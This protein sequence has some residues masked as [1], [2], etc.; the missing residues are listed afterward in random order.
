MP[1]AKKRDRAVDATRKPQRAH[2]RPAG[3]PRP[4]PSVPVTIVRTSA[5]AVT[6]EHSLPAVPVIVLGHDELVA[7]DEG[8]AAL[9]ACREIFV[10][11]GKLAWLAP[12]SSDVAS[13]R[14]RFP[15]S[16][17]EPLPNTRLRELLSHHARWVLPSRDDPSQFE[18][19]PVPV[20]AVNAIAARRQW[21]GLRLL[22]GLVTTP[23]LRA[24]GTLV[25]EPGYDPATQ[26]FYA[27]DRAYPPVPPAPDLAAARGALE[28][29]HCFVLRIPFAT[30]ADRATWVASIL[31]TFARH[32]VPSPIFFLE[33][34]REAPSVS[35][36]VG[37]TASVV[38]DGPGSARL[39]DELISAGSF[40]IRDLRR[41]SVPVW[42]MAV[43]APDASLKSLVSQSRHVGPRPA[44]TLFLAAPK[45]DAGFD[46]RGPVAR[47]RLETAN[48]ERVAV[49]EAMQA[50]VVS[51]NGG[52][53][54]G[55]LV[56]AA[57]T[58]L[59]AWIVAG[60]PGVPADR[61]A[62]KGFDAW[63]E[64]VRAALLWC[65][66]ADPIDTIADGPNDEELAYTHTAELVAGWA[67]VAKEF[68]GECTVREFFDA[69]ERRAATAHPKLRAALAFLVPGPLTAR[70][71]ADRLGRLLTRV[72][73]EPVR[74][75]QL[76]RTGSGNKGNRWAVRSVVS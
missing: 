18:S 5:E 57:L 52:D 68:G 70:K 74:G 37:L 21:P 48:T 28:D 75:L 73:A 24:D 23:V 25:E 55:A 61:R 4:R 72:S 14:N 39:H 69:L 59:R 8:I 7:A 36:L 66:E 65:G 10:R 53:Q 62:W 32:V 9:A 30:P 26:L 56:A 63:S 38:G 50:P 34:Q 54:R 20:W 11:N 33:T 44:T 46:A 13:G 60:R 76:R 58:L 22:A 35:G 67:E 17:I 6:T 43:G 16:R 47:I 15:S 40:S 71:T 29:L 1:P 64:M 31:S 41:S 49:G 12:T 2:R 3:G 51:R 42:A 19:A 27:P 45:L